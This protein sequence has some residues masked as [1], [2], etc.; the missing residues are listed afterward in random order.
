[1]DRGLKL[2]KVGPSFSSYNAMPIVRIDKI[3]TSGKMHLSF[4]KFSLLIR[5][6]NV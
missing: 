4:M 5:F 6:G 1:M 3:I 2:E